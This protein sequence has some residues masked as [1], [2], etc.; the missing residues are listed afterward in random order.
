[1]FSETYYLPMYEISPYEIFADKVI[2]FDVNFFNPKEDEVA[3]QASDDIEEL[4][5]Y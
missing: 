5:R 4:A 3:Q 2:L 1:M